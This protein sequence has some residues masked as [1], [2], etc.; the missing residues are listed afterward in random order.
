MARTTRWSP[1]AVAT[2]RCTRCRRRGSPTR[3]PE[4]PAAPGEAAMRDL[5]RGLGLM[6]RMSFA[7]DAARSVAALITAAGQ[8]AS[9]PFRAAGMKVL[10]D[11]MVAH[12]ARHAGIG[13]ALIAGITALGRVMAWASL[14]VRMRLR[15]NTQLHVDARL[16]ALTAGIPGLEHH[17]RPDYLDKVELVRSEREA[18]ANPF[19]P[20][21]WTLAAVVTA[22]SAVALLASV[23]PLLAVLP[24]FALPSVIATIRAERAD[25]DLRVEQAEAGRRL[26]HLFELT[27]EAS[28]AKEIRIFGLAGE[29][30]GR[31]R[32]LFDE[33]E[34]ARV[35]RAVRSAA[36]TSLGWAI[37]GAGYL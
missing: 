15:E 19:N 4:A 27:T 16:M 2:P 14:N 1:P 12:D 26:R 30:I 33:L 11:G 28:A 17:E 9:V 23:H 10:V 18:L 21:S 13:V 32:A 6:I 31:R 8:E 7:A 29:L 25:D 3:P 5:L 35:R 37:F 20:I 36:L 34:R 22:A 24:V